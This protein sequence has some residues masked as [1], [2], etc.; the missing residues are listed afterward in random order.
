MGASFVLSEQCRT[1]LGQPICDTDWETEK[2]GLTL[3]ALVDPL[4]AAAERVA[5]QHG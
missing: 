3:V 2:L 1:K 4:I 5:A